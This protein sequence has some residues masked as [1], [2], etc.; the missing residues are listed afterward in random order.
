MLPFRSS[1]S[2]SQI[3]GSQCS[4]SS[5]LCSLRSLRSFFSPLLS[6]RYTFGSASTPSAPRD[7]RVN[8][9]SERVT[10]ERMETWHR[11]TL[12]LWLAKDNRFLNPKS[13][14]KRILM[15]P[16]CRFIWLG[17]SGRESFAPSSFLWLTLHSHPASLSVGSSSLLSSLAHPRLRRDGVKCG[18]TKD[19]EHDTTERQEVKGKDEP[20]GRNRGGMVGLF[21]VALY[22]SIPLT[23]L[24]L[25]SFVSS[26][27]P[28]VPRS[29]L[30]PFVTRGERREH[31]VR[32]GVKG[33]RCE[34]VT[35][36]GV[37]SDVTRERGLL[38]VHCQP[39][40]ILLLHITS[41]SRAEGSGTR[42]EVR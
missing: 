23:P 37:K 41:S 35:R 28:Y 25:P 32:E 38:P 29:S 21:T 42:P 30:T 15:A 18:E 13:S 36:T 19:T 16:S 33:A 34:R 1:L 2:N 22:L 8:G 26:L 24:L 14:Y 10:R 31:R 39:L 17:W 40:L 6:C 27:A 9:E 12:D 4:L 3:L 11:L 20:T 5:L 7:E